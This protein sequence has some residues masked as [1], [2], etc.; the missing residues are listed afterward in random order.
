MSNLCCSCLSAAQSQLISR[1]A[2]SQADKQRAGE[3]GGASD[4]SVGEIEMSSGSSVHQ[5]TL[6]HCVKHIS[7]ARSLS[8]YC[9]LTRTVKMFGWWKLLLLGFWLIGLSQGR[10]AVAGDWHEVSWVYIPSRCVY[11]ERTLPSRHPNPIRQSLRTNR[12][13]RRIHRSTISI[14]RVYEMKLTTWCG[15]QRSPG[16]WQMPYS[17]ENI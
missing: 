16:L 1:Q 5:L 4:E 11:S 12:P 13:R 15:L 9:F 3:G 8:R 6:R 2:D 7:L 17:I 10:A 14:H